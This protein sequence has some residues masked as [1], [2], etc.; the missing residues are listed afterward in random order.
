M[1]MEAARS[2]NVSRQWQVRPKRSLPAWRNENRTSD[3][4]KMES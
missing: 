2:V 4:W 3:Q 1:F